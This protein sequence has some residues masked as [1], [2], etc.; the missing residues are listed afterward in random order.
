MLSCICR[1]LRAL[2][3]MYIS[4]STRDGRDITRSRSSRKMVLV[5]ILQV[6]SHHGQGIQPR[7]LSVVYQGGCQSTPPPR[8]II[9]SFQACIN[10]YCLKPFLDTRTL[11]LALLSL[12]SSS[13]ATHQHISEPRS[14]VQ[15]SLIL[16][17]AHFKT[18][19]AALNWW[20]WSIKVGV[21][22]KFFAHILSSTPLCKFLDTPM[23]VLG[24][25]QGQTSDSMT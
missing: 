12:A 18:G 15:V 2:A 23:I 10:N 11:N 3:A 9:R 17:N 5:D 14:Q 13:I 24:N 1:V 8:Y 6:H 4:L 25:S 22:A 21:A 20:V 16:N 7:I 19:V